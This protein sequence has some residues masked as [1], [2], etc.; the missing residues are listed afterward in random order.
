M[1]VIL[2]QDEMKPK[3][4]YLRFCVIVALADVLGVESD[5]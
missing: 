3:N 1:A 5:Y 4:C 2:S